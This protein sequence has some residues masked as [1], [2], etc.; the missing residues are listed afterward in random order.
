MNRETAFKNE[1]ITISTL[2]T[3]LK[4][5][6]QLLVTIILIVVYRLG[7]LVPIPFLNAEGIIDQFNTTTL[8]NPTD[9]QFSI[10]ML[11]IMP[12]VSAY[13]LVEIFSLFIPFLKKLRPGDYQGRLKLKRIA[14]I[15][16]LGLAIFHATSL[17]KGLK[18]WRLSDSQSVLTISNTFEYV[19]LV[20]V[21]VGCFFLL[22]A[23]CELITRFGIGHGISIILLSGICGHF[24]GGIPMLFKRLEHYGFSSYLIAIIAFCALIFV[25]LILLKTKISIPCYH[26]KDNTTVDYFQLNLSPS[27]MAALSYA[28][29]IV[30]LPVTL[31]H[32]FG[33]EGSMADNLSPGSFWYNMISCVFVFVFSFLFGWAFL[34]PQRRVS[35]MRAR[36]WHI[37]DIET[38][39]ESFILKRQFIYNLPPR[40]TVVS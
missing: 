13:I 11:G 33:I 36:G 28:A 14:L 27:S 34:H 6:R 9:E 1:V 20:A 16:A 35:K 37:A 21:L 24:I 22:V 4:F 30:M 12:Y 17:I 3:N 8:Y 38:T 18:S 26:E 7:I 19:V 23:I 40:S 5:I 10:F 39:A 29:S 31:T 25:T 15:L 2:N 32:F